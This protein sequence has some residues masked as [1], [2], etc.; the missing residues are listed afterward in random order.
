[1]SKITL[2][3]CLLSY[4]ACAVIFSYFLQTSRGEFDSSEFEVRRRYQDFLWLKEKLEE[5]HPTLIIPVCLLFF[6]FHG[7]A[8]ILSCESL[9][10]LNTQF[11]TFDS[12]QSIYLGNICF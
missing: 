8:A 4:I 3:K 2:G 11:Q 5:A 1:M 12:V 10:C 7:I 6:F 9:E